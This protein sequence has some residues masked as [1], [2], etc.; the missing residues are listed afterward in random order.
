MS[1]VKTIIILAAVFHGICVFR[2]K[3]L[4]VANGASLG[5]SAAP[6]G[7]RWDM[8]RCCM[9]MA[10]AGATWQGDS[11]GLHMLLHLMTHSMC[12]VQLRGFQA[13]WMVASSDTAHR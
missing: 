11:W 8:L 1:L 4:K 3:T 10:R 13:G 7:S 6:A 5:H 9:S 12:L 2:G